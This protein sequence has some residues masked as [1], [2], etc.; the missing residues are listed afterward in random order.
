MAFGSGWGGGIGSDDGGG[1]SGSSDV[2]PP[3]LA[4]FSPPLGTA[5]GR[6]DQ[7]HFTVTDDVAIRRVIIVA[8]YTATGIDE[9]VFDGDNFCGAY[10]GRSRREVIANGFRYTV[11][12]G[13]GGFPSQPI[14]RT[15]AIDQ[16][17]NENA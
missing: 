8:A 9:L 15:F 5:I 6:T 13:R 4:D 7:I 11:A 3:V 2:T 12:R 10:A 17:G 14:F 1:G 16:S